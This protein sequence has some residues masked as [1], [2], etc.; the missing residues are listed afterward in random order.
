MMPPPPKIQR[1]ARVQPMA[2]SAR[3]ARGS[4][5]RWRNEVVVV[6][7][8]VV[9]PPGEGEDGKEDEGVEVEV[10]R[11]QPSVRAVKRMRVDVRR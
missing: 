11:G 7:V 4:R 2:V 10:V 5:I 1:S 9:P 3:R 8:V 6:G